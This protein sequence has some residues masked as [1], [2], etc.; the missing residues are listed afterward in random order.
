MAQTSEDLTKAQWDPVHHFHHW[1]KPYLGYYLMDD[2]FVIRK[3]GQMLADAGVDTLVFDVPN[4]ITYD[5]IWSKIGNIYTDMRLKHIRTPQFCFITWSR[6]QENVKKLYRNLYQQNFYQN[7]CPEVRNFFTIRTSWAWT[8]GTAWYGDGQHEQTTVTIND[9]PTSNLGRSHDGLSHTQPNNH[10][11]SSERYFSQQ[12]ER[13]L[14]IDPSFIFITGWNE[15]IAQRFL[16]QN[17]TI[18][19]LGKNWSVNTTYFVD[20]FSQEYSRDAEPMEGGY[21]DNY[22]YQLVGYIRRFKG[23]SPIQSPTSPKT[24]LINKDFRQ[25]HGVGPFYLDDLCDI[26]T[27]NHSRYGNKG[28]HLIDTS[29]KNDLA[30]MQVARDASNVYF[31][32]R[33]RTPW[34]N[35]NAFNWLLLNTDNNY[36]TGWLGFDYLVDV[37]AGELK[38]SIDSSGQWQY[39]AN[40]TV[41]N[42]GDNELHFALSHRLL[43]IS[44][45]KMTLQFK[46][47]SADRLYTTS[48]LNFIDKG[49]AAPNGRFTYT[50]SASI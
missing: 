7:L 36:R 29:Q 21:G 20:L 1:E 11:P 50:Y 6:S 9:H 18:P 3:H 34:L 27:C 19:F 14:Q 13:A 35:G 31:Y 33:S 26:P 48:P 23:M 42:S 8:Q 32:A 17:P 25:W 47:F 38:K 49:D 5:N 41:V 39:Q 4:A 30:V 15:W 24:I 46:W 22:Y 45:T 16:Q 12:W 10:D 43:N 28:G 37:G 40:V 44:G 2:E